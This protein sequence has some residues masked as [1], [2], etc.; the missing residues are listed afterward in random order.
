M[1][2]PGW[3]AA[4]WTWPGV[5][6]N[7]GLAGLSSQ[8]RYPVF[9]ATRQDAGLPRSCTSMISGRRSELKE[10]NAHRV[11]ARTAAEAMP[12]HLASAAVQ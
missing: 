4:T 7:G 8:K 11:M 10:E 9:S 5:C 3:E 2:I 6:Q 12:R 1:G